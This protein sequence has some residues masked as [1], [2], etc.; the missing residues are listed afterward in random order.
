MTGKQGH[1]GYLLAHVSR[2]GETNSKGSSGQDKL[3]TVRTLPGVSVT[4]TLLL[5]INY[6]DDDVDLRL[7]LFLLRR[8]GP[9]NTQ[10][11]GTFI[12]STAFCGNDGNGSEY[13]FFVGR[14]TVDSHGTKR[15][16]KSPCTT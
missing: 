11:I 5:A 6:V 8:T 7:H 14:F 15:T 3:L 4:A 1:D 9:Y 10:C 2:D 12:G 13:P 16:G